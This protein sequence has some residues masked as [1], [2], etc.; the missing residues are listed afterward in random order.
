MELLEQ[1]IQILKP[2]IEKYFAIDKSG[3]DLE[4]LY[5]VKNNALYLQS[6]EGGDRLIIAISALLHDVHRIMSIQLDRYV[7][8]EESITKVQEFLNLLPLNEEQKQ[9][10]CYAI[11]HHEEYNFGQDK[12]SVTDIESLI[13]QDADNL[14]AVGAIGLVRTLQYGVSHSIKI[15]EKE[16]PLFYD[17]YSEQKNAKETTIQHIHNKLLRLPENMNTKTAKKEA[18]KRNKLMEKFLIQFIK[19]WNCN[20]ENN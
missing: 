15:Y 18:K 8:P 11:A 17:N 3:H 2:N 4:H 14:D 19:E 10:I 12:V 5:R 20:F 13:L 6:K 16:T 7:S 9:H 1:C